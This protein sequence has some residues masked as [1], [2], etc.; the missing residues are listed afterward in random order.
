MAILNQYGRPVARSRRNRFGD[1]LARYDAAQTTD[2]NMRHW[3]NADGLSS[4]VANNP[5]VRTR[6]RNRS[7]YETANNSYCRSMVDTLAADV[8]GTGPRVQIHSGNEEA[9]RWLEHEWLSWAREVRLAD[10]LR[11]MRRAKAVDGEAVAILTTRRQ[12]PTPVKLFLRPIECDRLSTPKAVF[13]DNEVDGIQFDN[14]GEP[15]RYSVLKH[16]PGGMTWGVFDEAQWYPARDVVHLFRHDR[17]EQHRGIPELTPALALFSQLRR[18]TLATLAAAETAADFAAVIQTAQL[19]GEGYAADDSDGISPEPL[20]VFEL[21]QRMVTVLPEGYQLGQVRAEHPTTTYGEFKREILAEA[22]ASL[23]MPYN[24][25]AHDSSGFNFASGKLDRLTYARTVSVERQ[26][27]DQLCNYRLFGAWFDEAILIPGYMPQ[28]LLSGTP[29]LSQWDVVFHWDGLD[30]IDPAK[31][32]NARRVE[33]ETGQRSLPSIY[34]DRGED[35]EAEMDRNAEA[36]GLSL[37][38]YR[39]RLVDKLFGTQ[40]VAQAREGALDD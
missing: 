5:G 26:E 18:F 25:G 22:F 23:C 29:P 15:V 14:D 30:D 17:P 39:K 16:H 4:D 33:L 6:L 3:N 40:Q 28:G 32:A 19:P 21:S 37:D 24:V 8:I 38:E 2:E 12:L 13:G 9:D 1:L 7:R 31:A 10:R 11:T 27:W 36:L 35:F 20:D 34:A